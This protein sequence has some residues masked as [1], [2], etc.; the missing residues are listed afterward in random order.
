MNAESQLKDFASR[1]TQAWCGQNP[2]AVSQFFAPNASL[3][4]NGGAPAVGRMAITSAA[5]EFMR[6]FPDLCITMHRLI[7][8]DERVEFHWT[9]D[10]HN[11][12]PGGSGHRVRISGFEEW[13]IGRDGLIADSQGHFDATEYQRQIEHGYDGRDAEAV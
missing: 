9:L 6:D 5:Q 2:A 3:T 4:I 8:R 7:Q 10:G 11:T 13:K 12:G 1:Y